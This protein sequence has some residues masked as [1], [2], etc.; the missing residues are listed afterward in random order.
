[1]NYPIFSFYFILLF[2]LGIMG[3]CILL[4][5]GLLGSTSAET[6]VFYSKAKDTYAAYG[7]WILTFTVDL[8]PY[9]YHLDHMYCEIHDFKTTVQE[10]IEKGQGKSL[11]KTFQ[12]QFAILANST[13][14]LIMAELKTFRGRFNNVKIK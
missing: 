12:V 14:D 11:S 8:R 10:M 4:I 5:L 9:K 7:S 2:C 13:N 3:F 6:G 1:M